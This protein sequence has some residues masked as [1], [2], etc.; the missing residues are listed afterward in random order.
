M[1]VHTGVNKDSDLIHS[2]IVT[3]ANMHNL[4]PAADLSHGDEQVVYGDAGYQGIAKRPEIEG[5]KAEFRVAMW[6]GKQR[7]P[8]NT[9]EGKLQDPCTDSPDQSSSGSRSSTD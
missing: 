7:A 4:T 5:A 2:A 3:T 8:A 9:P 6:P 1:K